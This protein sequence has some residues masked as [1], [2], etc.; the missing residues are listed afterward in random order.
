MG[1]TK[2]RY[3]VRRLLALILAAAMSVTMLPSTA[4]AAPE[5]IVDSAV[6]S[7]A[8]ST[9][10]V[11]GGDNT[12]EDSAVPVGDTTEGDSTA[13]VSDT[14]DGDNTAA[15]GDAAGG[16]TAAPADDIA[17]SNNEE[18]T[19]S[20]ADGDR[21]EVN[22]QDV[23]TAANPGYEITL[24][25]DYATEVEYDG[26]EQFSD[27]LNAVALKKDGEEV[28]PS[29]VTVTWKQKGADG[30]YAAMA[31][32]AKPKNAGDYQA[33]LSYPKQDGV[34]DGATLT[35]DCV[36]EKAPVDINVRADAKPGEAA[37]TVNVFI[38]SAAG[39]NGE[40]SKDDILLEKTGLRDAI[41]GVAVK[42]EDTLA[43]DVDYVVDVKLSFKA[44]AAKQTVYSNYD[45]EES[46][47]VDVAMGDLTRTQVVVTLAEK[48]NKDGVITRVYDGKPVKDPEITTDYTYEVQYWDDAAGWK[49][50]DNAEVSG[51]WVKWENEEEVVVSAPTD[52]GGYTYHLVYQ[53]S[54]GKY[55]KSEEGFIDVAVDPAKV[56]V[57]LTPATLE[58]VGGQTM[59]EVLSKVAYS[60]KTVDRD[61]KSVTIDVTKNH[62]WG[63]GY[64]DSNVSQVYEP[65]FTLQVKE[66]NVWEYVLDVRYRMIAGKEYRIIFDGTKAVYN[67]NG[68]YAHRT[69]INSGLDEEGEQIV[70]IDSNYETDTTPTA[71]DKAITFK[72]KDAVEL[73]WNIVGLL[74]DG[75]AGDTPEKAGDLTYTGEEI[76]K[77]RNEY[78]SKVKL[79]TFDAVGED[80]TYTWYR[81]SAAVDLIDKEIMDQNKANGFSAEEFNDCWEEY[82]PGL[83]AP[84]D[85]GIYKL[86]ISYTD[87]TDDGTFYYAKDNKPA[88]VYYVIKKVEFTVTP[89]GT[90]ETMSGR[91][92]NDFFADEEIAYDISP[93]MPAGM[94][95]YRPI[96]EVVEQT[97]LEGSEQVDEKSYREA[98]YAEGEAEFDAASTKSYQIQASGEIGYWYAG[99]A[100]F[101]VDPNFTT[102]KH[103]KAETDVDG[104]KQASDKWTPLGTSIPLKVNPVGTAKLTPAATATPALF[105]KEYDG[106]TFTQEEINAK[107]QPAYTI[108]K[109]DGQ[110]VTAEEIGAEFKCY[111]PYYGYYLE[112]LPLENVEEAGEYDLYL[113]F[114]G[115]E[116]YAPF[117]DADGNPVEVKIGTVKI[118]PRTIKVETKVQDTYEAGYL[119]NT[120]LLE[121][122][123]AEAKVTGAVPEQEKAFTDGAAWA[124]GPE[125][126]GFYVREKGSKESASILHRNKTYELWFDHEYSQLS[127]WGSYVGADGRWVTVDFARN[128]RVDSTEALAE[129]KVVAAPARLES[130]NLGTKVKSLRTAEPVVTRDKNDNITQKVDILEG[131][132][133]GSYSGEDANGAPVNLTGN[134][135]AFQIY[136]PEEFDGQRPDTAL[137]WN[138]VEKA[139]GRVMAEHK[140]SFVVLFDAA[141]G[142]P[143]F[144]VRWEDKY[145]EDFTL[146]FT[147]ENLLGNLE[148]AVAPKSLAF[149]DAPK[150]LALGSSQQLDVKITKAQMSDIISLGYK[151]SDDTVL[152]VNE[153]GW[154]TAL[155][156]G[157]A[158][159]TVYPQHM[160]ET[161]KMVPLTGK[162]VKEAKVTI[163]AAPV[164]AP[165][166]VTVSAYDNYAFVYYATPADG[167]RREIYVVDNNKH[168]DLKTADK[169][170][171]EV[172]K[173]RGN[174]N[175]WKNTFAIAPVYL[176]SADEVY[177]R[178]RRIG[179]YTALLDGLDPQGQYTVYVRNV[180][181]AKTWEL[182]DGSRITI[183]QETVDESAAGTAVSFKTQ[184]AETIGLDL[185]L[186]ETVDGITDVTEYDN[187]GD[188]SKFYEGDRYYR[189]DFSKL[190]KGIDSKTLGLFW[191]SEM[192]DTADSND[193][194][195]TELPLKNK[196][197]DGKKLSDIYEEP[198]LEYYVWAVDKKTGRSV[199]AQKNDYVSIDKKGKIK[200]T[201]VDIEDPIWVYVRN[202]NTGDTAGIGLKVIADVDAVTAKKK[203]VTLSVGQE[204]KL[205]NQELYSYTAGGKKL[206]G[207]RYPDITVDRALKDVVKAKEEW[208][209]LD[210]DD[211]GEYIIRAVKEGGTMELALT[212]ENVAK[213]YPDKAT[214]NITFTSKALEPVK[215][216]K[217]CDVMHDRFGLLFTYVGGADRFR[218]EITDSSKVKIFDKTYE[219]YDIEKLDEVSGKAVKDTYRI[220]AETIKRDVEASG[221][222]RAK[223]AKDSQ[224]TVTVT[225]LYDA[226]LSKPAAAKVKTTKIPATTTPL[227]DYWYEAEDGKYALHKVFGGMEI[228]VSE[229]SGSLPNADNTLSILSGNSY[230]LT[231]KASNRGRVNDTLVWTIG[232]KKVASVKA[233]AGTYCI[234]LNGL[235]AGNTTLEVTSKILGKAVA[236]YHITVIPVG[237]AYKNSNNT[238]RY[239]GDNE[240]SDYDAPNVQGGITEER[241]DY[242]PLSVGDPRK[243]LAS[244]YNY[245]SFTVPETGKYT[246]WAT[247]DGSHDNVKLDKL[248]EAAPGEWKWEKVNVGY[249]DGAADL[250]WLKKDQTVRLR[251]RVSDGDSY[252]YLY[253]MAINGAY[254]VGIEMEQGIETVEAG[255]PLTVTGQG[256]NE[257]IQFTA[258]ESG[259]YQFTLSD[260][261]NKKQTLY[262]YANENAAIGNGTSGADMS[263]TAIDYSVAAENSVWLKT[264]SLK[265]GETYTLETVKISEDGSVG[266]PKEITLAADDAKYL[267][268]TI[269][270]D[271]RYAFSSTADTENYN[272]SGSIE[273]NGE[274]KAYISSNKFSEKLELKQKDVVTLKITNNGTAEAKLT[275]K[276]EDITPADLSTVTGDKAIPN[277]SDTLYQ[278]TA[279]AAGAYKFTLTVDQAK[280][281]DAEL[282]IWN[283]ISDIENYESPL[284]QSSTAV[285]VETKAVISVG[286]LLKAGQTV[287]V[288]PVN[289]SGQEM[290][291]ACSGALDT[292][293]TEIKAGEAGAPVAV[294]AE[295]TKV[296]FTANA[297]GIYTFTTETLS[298]DVTF[299][300]YKNGAYAGGNTQNAD[301][302]VS[303]NNGD[304]LSKKLL[305][306]KGQTIVWNM[307]ADSETNLTLSAA[308]TREVKELTLDQPMTAS[309]VGY[310]DAPDGQAAADGFVFT[311]PEDGE[312]TFW[313]DKNYSISYGYIST[314]GVLYDIDKVNADTCMQHDTSYDYNSLTYD[315]NSGPGYNNFAIYYYLSEGQVVYLKSMSY[316]SYNTATFDVCVGK[317]YEP[318]NNN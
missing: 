12:D 169:I 111:D 214:V 226:I 20:A 263:G 52:V 101:I 316:S 211:N 90:Y 279:P 291:A 208:F 145:T 200:L 302:E 33:E 43:R 242:L 237:D 318:W 1:K 70:G 156:R 133:Y 294:K 221:Q 227:G 293:M 236:R 65:A 110:T 87:N 24:D 127:S 193:G 135:A 137:Y 36:I 199:R 91:T 248:S 153:Y 154:V 105:E 159:I 39:V 141:K 205:N 112:E 34:H 97:K 314:Y 239:Y 166:P 269:E 40:L 312:Y 53:D 55:A 246:F 75:K 228:D 157:K 63:T 98:D 252:N 194:I 168:S 288:N 265:D 273:V 234:T 18:G 89:K 216:L 287:Y 130:T 251:T 2:K 136:A 204:M 271:G 224:Y 174:K 197:V 317:G 179:D 235:K 61:N 57:E 247:R 128:Y 131:I 258:A 276:A 180:C 143:T 284:A 48:W 86:E 217:A 19:D 47:A 274:E 225:A 230:T 292:G 38:E 307:K 114:E 106:K 22:A 177:N 206:T 203:S 124:D 231:A 275:V 50:L 83:I 192:D 283:R 218:V 10:D 238:Y 113:C 73:E 123:T 4:M 290:T 210:K 223:L 69:D 285:T 244:T 117:T 299:E 315:S 282:K 308:L 306:Q 125:G 25:V 77:E 190:S 118:N 146:N 198:K 245:F 167:Y 28:D 6:E 266:T 9:S 152:H 82:E 115:S 96:W 201:G 147:E 108:T 212:D 59:T 132:V 262:L 80:F 66:G 280:A 17:G 58:V 172:K 121:E 85:A 30:N 301:D 103:E 268:Y 196:E 241:P 260:S 149:N 148:D 181:A 165:K 78:K 303:V 243:V 99:D 256:R 72:V 222:V 163:E 289:H 188:M 122:A 42:P 310:N 250:G 305:L 254:Y 15:E 81:N 44:D 233:A 261:A 16:D 264:K 240:P 64:D 27:I 209:E 109:A 29:A 202:T 295:G 140:D 32:G 31:E 41:T 138:E 213:N 164:T 95:A 296:T 49:K 88:E 68:S 126:I 281:A 175:Q 187:A 189:V 120:G 116:E 158:D 215:G 11:G 182:S 178:N 14:T 79:G 249:F 51:E 21:S 184:K 150:K 313:S 255:K 93:Q 195:W 76:Y 219:N 84:K 298:A 104:K 46:I 171:P 257:I 229:T 300:V 139:G 259:Y 176:D 60:A 232:D 67:A 100:A 129:F 162:G 7:E 278:F 26:S 207:Y 3:L 13:S 267:V 170:E 286:I 311:V 270:K 142:A 62:I 45:L 185:K 220:S 144:T 155:K 134:L 272:V 74:S 8:V 183:T 186:D 5:D 107:V 92:I 37:S 173:L 253:L 94:E 102:Y 309:V 151:S 161:G 23:T 304:S 71:D 56:V 191:H 160:D 119:D 277:G 54:T 297:T 35:K